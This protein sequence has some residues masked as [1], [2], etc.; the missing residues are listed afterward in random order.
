MGTPAIEAESLLD[1]RN[2]EGIG[3]GQHTVCE[4][5]THVGGNQ[6]YGTAKS[7]S[8]T[9]VSVTGSLTRYVIRMPRSST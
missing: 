8:G 5:S 2:Q 3:S 1:W 9:L 7:Q 4:L 6:A